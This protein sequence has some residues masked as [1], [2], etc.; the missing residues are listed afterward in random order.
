LWRLALICCGIRLSKILDIPK[1]K[2]FKN[3]RYTE[4]YACEFLKTFYHQHLSTPHPQ[5]SLNSGLNLT[6]QRTTASSMSPSDIIYKDIKYDEQLGLIKLYKSNR[7]KGERCQVNYF[8]PALKIFLM[9]V[10][11]KRWLPCPLFYS[12]VP[13]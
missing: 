5:K 9:K 7:S 3:S 6:G 13:G 1:D 8:T 4:G 11:D 12:R 10:N 2:A